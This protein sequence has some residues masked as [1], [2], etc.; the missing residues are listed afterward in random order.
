MPR[1]EQTEFML[2]ALTR[3]LLAWIASRP[4]TYQ[5]TM[6]AWKSNCPRTPVWDDALIDG[7]VEVN[8]RGMVGLTAV[9]RKL[10]RP[11]TGADGSEPRSSQS[12]G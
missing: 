7:L 1:E 12:A 10:L 2:N 6:E 5:E 8:D 9:G 4:R 3:E 11:D